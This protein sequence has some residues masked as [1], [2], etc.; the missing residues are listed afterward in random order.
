MPT[1]QCS[2]TPWALTIEVLAWATVLHLLIGIPLG[3]LLARGRFRGRGLLDTLVTVPLVFPPVVIGY[4]FLLL[5]GSQGWLT[6][7]LPPALRPDIVFQPAGLVIAAFLAGLPLMVKPVQAA[8]KEVPQGLL[9]AAATLRAT[10]IDR[11]MTVE[12][13]LTRRG[14]AAG[15]TLAVGRGLGEIGISLMLGGNIV[16]R[17]ETVS[18]AIYN[19]VNDG[20]FAC[21]NEV[22]LLLAGIAA[23]AFFLV[24][25]FGAL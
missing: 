17:T 8:F 12:L 14:I 1:A 19:H 20:N 21:A 16:G 3:W 13:P 2:G 5:L 23:L 24:R 6:T 22:S 15:L 7:L 9:D 18:L 10:A 4:F 11:F 25:R